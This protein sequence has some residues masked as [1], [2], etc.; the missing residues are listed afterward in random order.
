MHGCMPERLRSRRRRL[1]AALVCAVLLPAVLNAVRADELRPF[2]AS[3][4][5]NWHGMTVAISSLKLERGQDDT[6][7]Y[8]S[9]SEP[10]GLGRLFSQ[11]PLMRSVLRVT[12]QG[13]QPLQ[14]HADAGNG[15][16]DRNAD[17]KFDWQANRVTGTYENTPVDLTLKPGVQDDL[18][19][20]IAMMVELLR[21]RTPENLS[22]VNKNSIREYHYAREREET[23][24]S[25][26][27]RVETIVY[28]SQ[29]TGSPRITRFWCASSRGFIPLRVEQRR[30]DQVEWTMEIQSLKRE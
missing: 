22:M 18:S 8:S 12:D 14:Y 17:L 26:V 27:G 24:D 29:H 25:A 6:W 11:R 13:E 19:V 28:S 9:R 30:E 15:S 10:R 5:W 20:Q 16:T 3:Y 4:A 23:I 7:I 1:L 2:E 21:G